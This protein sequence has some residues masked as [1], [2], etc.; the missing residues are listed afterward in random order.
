MRNSLQGNAPGL[1]GFFGKRPV[2][3]GGDTQMVD[4]DDDDDER[5]NNADRSQF[6]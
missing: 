3:F 6:W 1:I 2:P 5:M 4:D